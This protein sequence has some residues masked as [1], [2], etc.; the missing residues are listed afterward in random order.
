MEQKLDKEDL[1]KVSESRFVL[2]V[3]R[4]QDSM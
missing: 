2:G 4:R 1:A 3:K